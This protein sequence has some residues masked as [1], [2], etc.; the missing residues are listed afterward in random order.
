MSEVHN[1]GVLGEEFTAQRLQQRGYRILARNY[2]TPYGELDIIAATQK[3]IVFVE[4]KT[5]RDASMVPPEENVTLS[6]QKRLLRAALL[7]LQRY[8]TELQPRFDVAGVTMEPSGMVTGFH[9]LANAF[10]GKGL[11]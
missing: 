9:Y 1:T 2:H 8:P 3:Y 5:R 11:F 10:E 6:K 7:Y 4:V